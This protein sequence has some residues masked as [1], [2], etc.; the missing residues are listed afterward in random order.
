MSSSYDF[1][2]HYDG[3]SLENSLIDAGDL[4]T[5][6]SG[7]NEALTIIVHTCEPAVGCRLF[8]N[9]SL[10]KGSAIAD[11]QL[12]IGDAIGAVASLPLGQIVEQ[13]EQHVKTFIELVKLYKL[14]RGQPL[15]K[16]IQ[17]DEKGRF[18][19]VFNNC[20][21]NIGSITHNLYGRPD[22][23]D[24]LKKAF[25]PASKDPENRVDIVD[26]KQ[27]TL[28]SVT[29]QDVSSFT[30]SVDPQLEIQNLQGV[31][32][33]VRRACLDGDK[34]WGIKF[35]GQNF[36]ATVVDSDFLSKVENREIV[37]GHGDKLKVDAEVVQQKGA[38]KMSWTIKKVL[39]FVPN[40]EMQP[41]LF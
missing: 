27:N 22:V 25:S 10:R 4:G 12:F 23:S 21:I 7:F 41:A 1:S 9:A 31:Y 24:S 38:K 14:L 39:D 6:L 32:V 3:P 11:L 20:P 13:A 18:V 5:S 37:F 40:K 34:K 28:E 16:D 19:F 36:T 2:V 30:G 29:S 17:P 15:P 35:L 8:V 26:S 33:E